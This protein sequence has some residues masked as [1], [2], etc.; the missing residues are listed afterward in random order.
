M[1]AAK[2]DPQHQR[3]EIIIHEAL[4]TGDL[5]QLLESIEREATRLKPCWIAA[6]DMRGMWVDNPYIN[7]QFEAIQKTLMAC[8]AGKIGTLVDNASIRM[9]LIQAG[10]KTC[11]NV[12]T[13]RF[14]DVGDW[15]RF[16]TEA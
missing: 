10:T 1:Y 4:S 16:L 5:H 11:S 9:H 6:V 13:R 12:I 15:E 7:I 8:Q 2:A 14:F 3:M